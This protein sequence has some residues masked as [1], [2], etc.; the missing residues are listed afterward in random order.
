MGKNSELLFCSHTLLCFVK[1]VKDFLSKNLKL[2]R[3]INIGGH[4]FWDKGG[5]YTGVCLKK[6]LQPP[7]AARIFSPPGCEIFLSAGGFISRQ[8]CDP[9]NNK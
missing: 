6:I 2:Y 8:G 4:G 5:V 3:Y 7:S 1:R 9:N